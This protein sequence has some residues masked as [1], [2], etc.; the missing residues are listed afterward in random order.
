MVCTTF[1]RIR[2]GRSQLGGWSSR[3]SGPLLPL[4]LRAPELLTTPIAASYIP[5]RAEE[6]TSGYSLI[7]QFLNVELSPFHP[8]GIIRAL[9]PDRI[10]TTREDE[11]PEEDDMTAEGVVHIDKLELGFQELIQS[12]ALNNMAT[13]KRGGDGKNW[14]ANGDP[15]E[16]AIQVF[17]HKA[18]YGKPHM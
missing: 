1:A 9:N 13:L 17:A 5:W 15:T 16:I 8:R 18:G 2:L 6:S 14:E 11:F 10:D 7:A 3:K 4:Q 12:A